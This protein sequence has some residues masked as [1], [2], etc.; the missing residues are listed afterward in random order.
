MA[1]QD[2]IQKLSEA[3][4][5]RLKVYL[6][7][8]L[9]SGKTVLGASFAEAGLSGL[10]ID[11]PGELG[12]RSLPEA[13]KDRVDRVLVTTPDEF[14]DLQHY[15]IKDEKYDWVMIDSATS[16]QDMFLRAIQDK[17]QNRMAKFN[18]GGWE[19]DG[20]QMWGEA[21]DHMTNV[22]TF[23]FDLAEERNVKHPKHVIFTASSRELYDEK[24]NFKGVKIGVRGQGNESIYRAADYVLY[25]FK[26][27]KLLK[28]KGD[29]KGE[30]KTLY[31]V[32]LG[33]EDSVVDTKI[34][35]DVSLDRLPDVVGGEQRLT[36]PKFEKL[37][38]QTSKKEKK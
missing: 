2:R 4:E 8:K 1:I 26:E 10:Y 12:R 18:E 28:K 13:S 36:L 37:V 33:G 15:L 27:E 38:S 3:P 16:M 24:G 25:C 14:A 19:G 6:H 22:S 32:R 35:Q 21:L 20:R 7:G 34:R 9:G 30:R 5:A 29:L 23:Y 17:P 31:Y 11:F